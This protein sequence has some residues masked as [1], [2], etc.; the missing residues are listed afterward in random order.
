MHVYQLLPCL[1]VTHIMHEHMYVVCQSTLKSEFLF[2]FSFSF[3]KRVIFSCYLLRFLLPYH[4]LFSLSISL[5]LFS[6]SSYFVDR[7][8]RHI[9]THYLSLSL[10]SRQRATQNTNP[11]SQF[12]T[13]FSLIFSI[14]LCCWSVLWHEMKLTHFVPFGLTL[15]VYFDSWYTML[16]KPPCNITCNIILYPNIPTHIISH[17]NP[18]LSHSLYKHQQPYHFF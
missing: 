1:W 4:P 2:S 3:K 16:H 18:H 9:R 15:V 10:S 12:M 11:H 13:L 5:L 7:K 17:L 8:W 14:G 6:F